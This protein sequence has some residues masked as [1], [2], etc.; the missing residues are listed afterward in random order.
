M[1]EQKKQQQAEQVYQILCKMLD[2]KEVNYENHEEEL[3]VKFGMSGDDL[4]MQFLMFVDKD[5]YL[6]RLLSPMS[7]SVQEDKRVDMAL[8]INAINNRLP[9][10]SFDYE[11]ESGRICFRVASSFADCEIGAL[12]WEY[13]LY[14]ASVLVDEY[15]DKFLMFSKGA[16]TLEQLIA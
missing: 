1:E 3:L 8:A 9:E 15:N 11:I 10:G 6:L 12:V 2:D 7:F 14:M 5:R 4:P 13:L 16:I